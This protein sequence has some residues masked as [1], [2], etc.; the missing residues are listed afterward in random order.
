MFVWFF[1]WFFASSTGKIAATAEEREGLVG[2]F[3]FN[4][5]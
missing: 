4:L 3:V 1:V 5:I 2:P